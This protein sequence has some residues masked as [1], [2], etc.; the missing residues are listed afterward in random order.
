MAGQFSK[1]RSWVFID[2]I[3]EVTR[4]FDESNELTEA[5]RKHMMAAADL[6]VPLKVDVGTGTNW[7]QAH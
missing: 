4:F 1:V 7:D 5:V 6:R 2:G 3:D